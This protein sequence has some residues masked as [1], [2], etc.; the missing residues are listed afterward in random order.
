MTNPE[1]D[2]PRTLS[3]SGILAAARSALFGSAWTPLARSA[4]C[5]KQHR[6]LSVPGHSVVWI[7]RDAVPWAEWGE[8]HG[9]FEV[10]RMDG[11]PYL[12]AVGAPVV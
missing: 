11:L 4:W 7:R 9:Y 6:H 12:R 8:R 5:R 3:L 10:Q 2:E 1:R